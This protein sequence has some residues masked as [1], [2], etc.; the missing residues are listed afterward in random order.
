VKAPVHTDIVSFESTVVFLIHSI[1]AGSF[2]STPV[3]PP[4]TTRMSTRGT[5]AIE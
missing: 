5:S 1:I 3:F 4:G 2:S